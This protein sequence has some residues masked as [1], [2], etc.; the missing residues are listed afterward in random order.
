MH[1]DF[2]FNVWYNEGNQQRFVETQDYLS[3]NTVFVVIANPLILFAR[4]WN[5][6]I[7]NQLDAGPWEKS[8]NLKIYLG[9]ATCPDYT[10]L[11]L[12]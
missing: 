5:F 2:V 9:M 4:I 1:F 10:Y 11:C 6:L 7:L 3:L 8:A 12:F